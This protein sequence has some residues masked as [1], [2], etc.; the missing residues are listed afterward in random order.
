[1]GQRELRRLKSP[2]SSP[3]AYPPCSLL[4]SVMKQDVLA[5]AK[6]ASGEGGFHDVMLEL[7]SPLELGEKEAFQALDGLIRKLAEE[8]ESSRYGRD[9]VET[10]LRR[11]PLPCA[12]HYLAD[13]AF[14]F[15]QLF[16]QNKGELW[17]VEADIE[18]GQ[19]NLAIRSF[20]KEMA[21]AGDGPLPHSQY[22]HSTEVWSDD[23]DALFHHSHSFRRNQS[24]QVA[25]DRLGSV[26]D[27]A[28]CLWFREQV[29]VA[30]VASPTYH[31]IRH[32]QEGWT[33]LG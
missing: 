21:R 32:K 23:G 5:L 17:V 27:E 28:L 18:R 20:E 25:L 29:G 10:Q 4:R 30:L 26:D 3:P 24:P 6:R 33:D 1:V 8:P 31:T 19:E 15:I 16:F 14:V 12:F 7:L 2:L 13:P 11:M 22:F 9:F